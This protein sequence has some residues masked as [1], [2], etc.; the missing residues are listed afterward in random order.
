MD[1][2]SNLEAQEVSTPHG[3]RLVAEEV[4]PHVVVDTDDRQAPPSEKPH[5]LGTNQTGGASDDGDVH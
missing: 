5:R 1:V 3:G 2:A 4:P